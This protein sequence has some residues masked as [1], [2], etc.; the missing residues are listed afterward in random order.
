MHKDT[1]PAMKLDPHPAQEYTDP[2]DLE[3]KQLERLER[4]VWVAIGL[5][6]AALVAVLI[7]AGVSF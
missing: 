7:Y 4:V 5:T 2:M 3:I 1:G 6:S